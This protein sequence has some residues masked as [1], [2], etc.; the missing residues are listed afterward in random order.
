MLARILFQAATA[1]VPVTFAADDFRSACRDVL[2]QMD[3]LNAFT[4]T[5]RVPNISSSAEIVTVLRETNVFN[6][7]QCREVEKKLADRRSVR[8]SLCLGRLRF[9]LY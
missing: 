8:L 5:L 4:T 9:S 2:E 1:Y 6:E 3:V 7:Q